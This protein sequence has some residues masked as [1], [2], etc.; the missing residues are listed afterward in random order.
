[1]LGLLE[2]VTLTPDE[3]R[4]AHVEAVRAA[5]VSDHAINDALHVCYCFNLIDRLAD[6][7]GWH[8]QTAEQFDKDAKFL[9]KKGYNLIGPVRKRALATP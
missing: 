7:F 8:V 3:V 9:L 2:T 5:G 6:S 1:M 4:P